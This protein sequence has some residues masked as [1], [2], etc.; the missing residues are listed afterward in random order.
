MKRLLAF[1][2]V[3][4]VASM[5]VE[6]AKASVSHAPFGALPD[7]SPVERYTL[8]NASGMEV[9]LIDFGGIITAIKVPDR[10]GRL[11]DVVLG[12]DSLN[13]YVKNEPHL[14]SFVGRYANRIGKAQF[15]LDGKTYTLAANDNANTLHGGI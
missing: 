4:L 3:S 14:G 6:A 1:C 13:D 11:A 7:G 9:E 2:C 12:F 15:T 10:Q 5:S 8:A